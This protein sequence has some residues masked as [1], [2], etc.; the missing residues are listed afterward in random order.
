[1]IDESFVIFIFIFS[2]ELVNFDGVYY[3]VILL[4]FF[5]EKVIIFIWLVGI[6]LNKK[7]FWCVVC[8]DGVYVMKDGFVDFFIL[9]DVVV[10]LGYIQEYRE[11]DRLFNLIV[12]VNI[13][14][15]KEWDKDCVSVL[16]E[17]GVNWWIDG[18]LFVFEDLEILCK[19]IQD[20]LFLVQVVKNVFMICCI[21]V[22]CLFCQVEF[23]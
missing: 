15:D 7:L 18:I 13:I 23:Y 8:Y 1:M 16:E 22:F 10:I 6:W 20:G 5:E 9:Q 21:F 17:V 4:M 2:G 19:C 12:G 3:Y 14:N 11:S